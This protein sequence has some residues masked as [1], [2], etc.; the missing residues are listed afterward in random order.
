MV[1]HLRLLTHVSYTKNIHN[2]F[3][4]QLLVH[5]QKYCLKLA[6]KY[7]II[8][9]WTTCL[10][11]R[12][13]KLNWNQ[14]AKRIKAG[15]GFL[16]LGHLS[17]QPSFIFLWFEYYLRMRKSW[18]DCYNNFFGNLWTC[19]VITLIHLLMEINHW[20]LKMSCKCIKWHVSTFVLEII[21]FLEMARSVKLKAK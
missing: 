20:L 21:G 15:F 8:W 17:T 14:F 6:S 1:K 9:L 7:F 11:S 2:I 4:N 16:G 13:I 19:S 18:S 3:L 10:C 5:M 12:N